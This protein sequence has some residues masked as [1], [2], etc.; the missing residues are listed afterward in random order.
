MNPLFN[1][2]KNFL[3]FLYKNLIIF[4]VMILVIKGSYLLLLR[5]LPSSGV[6]NP[7]PK[8]K[9]IP[10]VSLKVS[11]IFG[12][13]APVQA[14]PAD[15]MKKDETS[16]LLDLK[17][18]AI[19]HSKSL[20]FVMLDDPSGVVLLDIGQTFKGYT[21]FIVH[22]D[23]AIFVKDYK[24]YELKIEDS[25]NKESAKK[26]KVVDYDAMKEEAV[27][28]IKS[29]TKAEVKKYQ[30]DSSKIWSNIGVDEYKVGG[31]IDGYIVNFVKK[32]S[33][34]WQFGLQKNDI[35]KEANGI[36]L[37]SRKDGLDILKKLDKMKVLTLTIIRNNQ[38]KELEYEI[39]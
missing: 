22:P 9:D 27:Q 20:S 14:A 10:F 3:A 7:I 15:G 32:D 4:A 8:D 13:S 23:K 1:I 17:L 29:I 6:S 16:F 24:Q 39:F 34:F 5:H 31:K 26:A 37:T 38:E 33:I 36:K 35:L 30:D 19:F 28:S 12:L 21:L 2:N 11:D 18:K 25:E